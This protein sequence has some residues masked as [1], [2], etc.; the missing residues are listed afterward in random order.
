MKFRLKWIL[1]T[2]MT[3]LLLMTY[4]HLEK[5]RDY[6]ETKLKKYQ[7]IKENL[8]PSQIN[9]DNLMQI[10][11][12]EPQKDWVKL[13]KAEVAQKWTQVEYEGALVG[14][15]TAG[16]RLEQVEIAMENADVEKEAP[17]A[18]SKSANLGTNRP[19]G[20][21]VSLADIEAKSAETK[22]KNVKVELEK[23]EVKLEN[24]KFESQNAEIHL[25]NTNTSTSHEEK[26][27]NVEINLQDAETEQKNTK[28]KLNCMAYLVLFPYIFLSQESCEIAITRSLRSYRSSVCHS[29]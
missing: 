19:Q 18:E 2:I 10:G 8:N 15:E 12:I 14:R 9:D 23:A 1:T 11:E 7:Q 25:K 20:K 4:L 28:V 22:L 3:S 27:G 24:A 21:L 26:L 29:N 6:F 5:Y 13:E 16:S 17:E